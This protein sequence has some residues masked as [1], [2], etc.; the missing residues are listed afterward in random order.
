MSQKQKY[1]GLRLKQNALKG[2]MDI[3]FTS[4][5]AD[6]VSERYFDTVKA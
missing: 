3:S 2:V 4:D 5:E 1:Q 6:V